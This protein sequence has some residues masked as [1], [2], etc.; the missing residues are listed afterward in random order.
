MFGLGL[1]KPDLILT[2]RVHVSCVA[3]VTSCSCQIVSEANNSASAFD[4]VDSRCS[5]FAVDGSSALVEFTAEPKFSQD[6]LQNI[7]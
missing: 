1:V 2:S 7:A 6:E 5:R 4:I 3:V